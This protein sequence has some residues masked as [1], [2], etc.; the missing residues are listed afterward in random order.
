MKL[1]I[2]KW[3]L[4]EL[5]VVEEEMEAAEQATTELGRTEHY[6][7]AGTALRCAADHINMLY[8]DMPKQGRDYFDYLAMKFVF[9]YEEWTRINN[10]PPFPHDNLE[11]LAVQ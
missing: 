5:L 10:R 2:K 7:N 6:Y 3:A 11:F 9:H 4:E 1:Q 8:Y